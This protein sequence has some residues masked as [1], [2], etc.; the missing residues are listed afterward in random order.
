VLKKELVKLL[1]NEIV[2]YCSCCD[3]VLGYKKIEDDF[4]V[5]ECKKCNIEFLFAVNIRE[6]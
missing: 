4:A 3:R 5:F 6:E 2:H 1:K